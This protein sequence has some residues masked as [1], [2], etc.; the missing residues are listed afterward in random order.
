[1]RTTFEEETVVED[2]G[3]VVVGCLRTHL[4]IRLS[5]HRLVPPRMTLKHSIALPARMTSGPQRLKLMTAVLRVTVVAAPNSASRREL[6][7]SP[8]IREAGRAT[9]VAPAKPMV[10]GDSLQSI[11]VC[12]I[13]AARIR[14]IDTT[15]KTKVTPH[16]IMDRSLSSQW[17]EISLRHHSA[18][19]ILRT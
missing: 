3:A 18:P 4:G 12:L 6:D 15:R 8:E 7:R 5:L 9:G 19:F 17:L 2:V 13:Q 10:I 11:L 14:M 16:T 1:M